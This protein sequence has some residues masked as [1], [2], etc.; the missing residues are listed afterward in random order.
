[1]EARVVLETTVIAGIPQEAGWGSVDAAQEG[2][3]DPRVHGGAR[4]PG[5]SLRTLAVA[6]EEVVA[7]RLRP[8]IVLRECVDAV[9][10]QRGRLS[11]RAAGGG[12]A[13]EVS[14]HVHRLIR[15]D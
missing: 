3:I 7:R 11:R 13:V 2:G 10:D 9:T 5:E 1:M 14:E 4:P 15:G 6:A 12:A 8:P